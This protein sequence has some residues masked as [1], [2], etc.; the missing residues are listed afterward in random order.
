MPP[1]RLL[2]A[3]DHAVVR[4][5]FASLLGYHSD[6]QIAGAAAN[7]REAIEQYEALRPDI[8]LMDLVMPG[9]GGVDAIKA[10]RRKYP[11]AR[12]IVLTTFDGDED[13]FRALEAGAQGYLLK[14]CTPSQLL[15]AIRTVHA[16]GTL[17]PAE[18][19]ERLAAR[20]MAGPALSPREIEVLRLIAAGKTNK[21][22][23]AA[24]FISEGTV[25]THVVSIYGKLG[26][27][28]RTGAVVT[29]MKRGILRL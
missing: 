19:S 26:V 7:G 11:D 2:I 5:G 8:T 9:T 18:V 28:D 10:I 12:I 3:E 13:I 22:I 15:D 17:V 20:A 21:E 23:G 1:I 29:A 16:G 4:E 14:D 24:L 6:M 25:K 27:E